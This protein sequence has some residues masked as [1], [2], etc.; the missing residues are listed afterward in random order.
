MFFVKYSSDS[1]VKVLTLYNDEAADSIRTVPTR[2]LFDN[3][4][5]AIN[6]NNTLL[7]DPMVLKANGSYP[8]GP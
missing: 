8:I 2:D 6:S 1:K 5:T 3:L 7:A 4:V